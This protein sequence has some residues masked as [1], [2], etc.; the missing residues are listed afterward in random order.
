MSR[1]VK[2]VSFG[3]K[4]IELIEFLEDKGQFSLYVKRLI[5]EEMER[6]RKAENPDP[7][8]VSPS[9]EEKIDEMLELLKSGKLIMSE[10]NEAPD[11]DDI[12]DELEV[13]DKQKEIMSGLMGHFHVS[14]K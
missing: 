12:G 4:D 1:E 7:I 11:V 9:I 6:Q 5:K 13:T 14:K 3:K 2:H 10:S 8:V